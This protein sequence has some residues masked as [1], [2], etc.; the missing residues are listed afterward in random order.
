MP[1]DGIVALQQKKIRAHLNWMN[2]KTKKKFMIQ[3]QI[4]FQN[5]KKNLQFSHRFKQKIHAL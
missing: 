1:Q 4:F 3:F 5:V 2:S